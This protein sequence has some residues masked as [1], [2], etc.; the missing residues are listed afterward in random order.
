MYMY[1]TRIY[2]IYLY[3][4]YIYPLYIKNFMFII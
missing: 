4:H 3:N 2:K 1:F